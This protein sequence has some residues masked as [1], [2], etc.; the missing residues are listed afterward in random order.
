MVIIQSQQRRDT[1]LCE[2]LERH[3]DEILMK[4]HVHMWD[5]IITK[6]NKLPI[7]PI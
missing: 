4:L 1:S 2:D 5:R 6:E 7:T 3:T